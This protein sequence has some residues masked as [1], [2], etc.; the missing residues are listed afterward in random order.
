MVDYSELIVT[1]IGIPNTQ[2]R[3]E[4]FFR[5]KHNRTARSSNVNLSPLSGDCQKTLWTALI[6]K[7]EKPNPTKKG[8]KAIANGAI[9]TAAH[10]ASAAPDFPWLP[11]YGNGLPMMMIADLFES[12]A[13]GTFQS[14][15]S[16]A[17]PFWTK[18]EN[19]R[20]AFQHFDSTKS[21]LFSDKD[22]KRFFR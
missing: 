4:T 2:C 12:S 14:G 15:L 13:V 7:L 16:W 1:L 5:Q 8:Q 11:R 18:R 6:S 10:G 3:L 9:T 19:F 20:S 21:A 22:V 17:K